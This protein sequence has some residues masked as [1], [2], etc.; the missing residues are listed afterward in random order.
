[1]RQFPFTL[2]L[3]LLVATLGAADDI[4]KQHYQLGQA[5]ERRGAQIEAY[6]QYVQAR[7]GDPSN[8]KY[9]RAANRLRAATA[10]VIALESTSALVDAESALADP[11]V[12]IADDFAATLPLR[13]ALGAMEL[14]V[15]QKIASFR[16]DGTIQEAYERV[17]EEYGIAVLFDDGFRGSEST[18]FHVDN[19]DFRDA[20]LTLNEVA[21]AF[22]IPLTAKLAMIAE[23]TPG[24]R[25]ELEP[26]VSIDVPIPEAATPQE[27]N[28]VAQAVQQTLEIRRLFVV[29]SQNVVTIRDSPAKA[30]M[31]RLLL[32]RLL[33]PHAEVVLEV[34]IISYNNSRDSEVGLDLPSAFPI[35]N[36]STVLNAIQPERSEGPEA[37]F[38]G[39]KSLFGIGVADAR[40]V[41]TLVA[42]TGST[43]QRMSVRASHGTEAQMRVGERFPIIAATFQPG[44]NI[45]PSGDNA[46][47]QLPPP[48]ISYE[49]LG[50]SINVTPTVH[51]GGEVTL[52]MQAEF[53]LLS[54]A[55]SNGIPILVNRTIETQVRL[56]AGESAIIA[57]M[58]ID[59]QRRTRSTPLGLVGIPIVSNALGRKKNQTNSTDL[60]ILVRPRIVRLPPADMVKELSIRFGSEE[61]PLSAL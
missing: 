17:F 15:E 31:A 50:L 55:G 39:G 27:A 42:G 19:V 45:E 30:R 13:E 51:E 25:T 5:A 44:S 28:E 48:T 33:V 52:K 26:V 34:E 37:V 3:T 36:Y 6:A 1:V 8:R 61:R 58:A 46:L 56:R 11:G 14:D 12:P 43:R 29:A 38:G 24:K 57:G 23:D 35:T 2:V 20:V 41:A 7:A 60:L 22:V 9:L 54:G 10:Q 16:L 59:E 47:F 21:K 40:L 49:D 53:N 18:R 32:E 4:A